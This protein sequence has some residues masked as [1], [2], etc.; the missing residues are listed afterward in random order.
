VGGRTIAHGSGVAWLLDRQAEAGR[1][2]VVPVLLP[3][4]EPPVGFLK[5][6]MWLDLRQRSIS[7]EDLDAWLAI[8][9]G[10]GTIPRKEP[11]ATICPYRGLLFFREEDAPFFFGR[12]KYTQGLLAKI[13]RHRFVAVVGASGSGKSSVVRAGLVPRLRAQKEPIVWEIATMMPRGE[14]LKSLVWSLAPMLWPDIT[15]PVD[16]REKAN[17]KANSLRGETSA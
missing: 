14:P 4:C 10:E 9:R 1:F 5:Q 8:V 15:D 16:L 6:L 11:G 12:D 13:E 2:P 17:E 3:G 7:E